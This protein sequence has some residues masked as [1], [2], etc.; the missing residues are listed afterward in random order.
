MIRGEPPVPTA[1]IQQLQVWRIAFH[2]LLDME[3]NDLL[4][5]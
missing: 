5:K 1:S 4:S 2:G 3:S